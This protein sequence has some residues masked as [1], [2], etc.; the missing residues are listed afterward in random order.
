VVGFFGSYGWGSKVDIQAKLQNLQTA[1]LPPVM[2]KGLP[3][4]EDFAM[5]EQMASEII[6]K[7]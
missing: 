2:V 7:A 5:I 6:K 1:F 3:E 4:K